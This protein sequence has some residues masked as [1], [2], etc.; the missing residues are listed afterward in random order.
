MSRSSTIDELGLSD[1]IAYKI[2]RFIIRYVAP[3]G[4]VVIFFNA[5][6]LFS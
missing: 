2:W 6:G 1:S 4:V 3:L 5:M